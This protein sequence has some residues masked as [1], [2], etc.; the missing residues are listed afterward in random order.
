MWIRFRWC[1]RIGKCNCT[2]DRNTVYLQEHSRTSEFKEVFLLRGRLT[3]LVQSNTFVLP[4][5]HYVHCIAQC[6][7][8]TLYCPMY[9][10]YYT[11]QHTAV[12]SNA[13]ES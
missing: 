9:T 13:N 6:T 10:M 8:C 2:L 11:P 1:I 7:L 3:L 12:Q 4:N 5:V